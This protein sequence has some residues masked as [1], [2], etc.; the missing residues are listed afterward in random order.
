MLS[1]TSCIKVEYPEDE[2][3]DYDNYYYSGKEKDIEL[4]TKTEHC[5]LQLIPVGIHVEFDSPSEDHSFIHSGGLCRA[6]SHMATQSTLLSMQ[7]GSSLVDT[8]PASLI[9][10]FM[11]EDTG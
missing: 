11:N 3:Q 10:V 4:L 9:R 7:A 5:F 1:S 8:T 2:K 6:K